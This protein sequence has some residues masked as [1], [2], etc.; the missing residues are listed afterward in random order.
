MMEAS[1]FFLSSALDE[2]EKE[3]PPALQMLLNKYSDDE[4]T[5]ITSV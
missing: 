3:A 5:A 1:G 4:H 2:V